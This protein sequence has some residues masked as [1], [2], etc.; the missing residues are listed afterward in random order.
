M[1]SGTPAR[2]IRYAKRPALAM[3]NMITD[4]EITDFFRI[5]QRSAMRISR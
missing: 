5:G 3:M 2:V 1:A 4:D